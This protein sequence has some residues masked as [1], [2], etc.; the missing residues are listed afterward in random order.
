M[1]S[2]KPDIDALRA[3]IAALERRTVLAG[4]PAGRAATARHDERNGEPELADLLALPGGLL[5][6][7]FATEQRHS[8]SALGFTLGLSRSLLAG[9]RQAMFYLQLHGEA[10]ELGLPY[11]VGLAGFGLDPDS[12]VICRIASLPELLWATEEALACRAVAGVILDVTGQP[13]ALDF[14]V[15]RRLSLRA[16]A[17]GASAFILRYG[18]ARAASA[19]QLRWRVEPEPSAGRPFDAAAPGPPRFRVE[20][21][22]RRLAGREAMENRTLILDWIDNGFVAFDSSRRAGSAPGRI[23][24]PSRPQPAA[25]GHGLS[26][27]G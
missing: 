15:S 14:T 27:A 23:A 6:E 19:A 17:A 20:I 3:Q 22:K 13:A 11:G 18:K 7:I 16:A 26:K 8:G 4:A 24:A 21:E 12:L 10:Q 9:R 2:L 1:D 5:H 25:L